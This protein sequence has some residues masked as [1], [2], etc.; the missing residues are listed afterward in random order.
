MKRIILF[1]LVFVSIQGFAQE[2]FTTGGDHFNNG[3]YRVSITIGEPISETVSA[4]NFLTQGQLQP[5]DDFSLSI[6]ETQHTALKVW[7]NPTVQFLQFNVE[8]TSELRIL[9]L[10][11]RTILMDQLFSGSQKIDL[12]SLPAGNYIIQ[13]SNEAEIASTHIIKTH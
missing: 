2:V 10:Q 1:S 12:G 3:D 6:R 4:T 5:Q 7:P 8:T 9:D 13:V 11:G